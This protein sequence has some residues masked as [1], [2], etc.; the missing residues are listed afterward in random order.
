VFRVGFV[1][2]IHFKPDVCAIFN[3]NTG[4]FE[5]V[6][7][8]RCNCNIGLNFIAG[9]ADQASDFW[10]HISRCN[11]LSGQG[12]LNGGVV[13]GICVYGCMLADFFAGF[14][15]CLDF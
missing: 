8:R 3:L 14:T 6:D 10:G 13:R 7:H 11:D 9:F 15:I 1:F 12:Q 2:F 5:F 4:D